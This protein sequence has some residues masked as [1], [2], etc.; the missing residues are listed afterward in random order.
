MYFL[1]NFGGLLGLCIGFSIVGFIEVVYFAT[2]KFYQNKFQ[3]KKPVPKNA[4]TAF[5]GIPT[6]KDIEIILINQNNFNQPK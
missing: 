6:Y 2:V 1:G 4:M 3:T 5:K